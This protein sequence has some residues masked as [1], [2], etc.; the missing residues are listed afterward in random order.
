[1]T[2]PSTFPGVRPGWRPTVRLPTTETANQ[3]VQSVDLLRGLV[4]VI[5]AIDHVRDYFTQSR[6][7]PTDLTQTTVPLFATRWITHYCAPI[8]IFLAGVSAWMA[9]RRR[10]PAELS[11]LLLTRGLWLIMLEVT[12]VNFAW[13]FNL[14]FPGGIGLQVIWAIG[15]SMVAMAG[16][17]RLSRGTIGL[18]AFGFMAGHN[19][20]DPLDASLGGNFFWAVLHAP[21]AFPELNLVVR[22]PVL[23]WIGVM[24][25]GYVLGPLLERPAAA[26]NRALLQLGFAALAAFVLLRTLGIYG[27][28]SPWVK[29]ENPVTTALSFFNVT[30]YPPS[31]EYILMTLGPALIGLVLLER[32]RGPLGVWLAAFGRAPFFYYIAH[33]Y[34]IHSLALLAGVATGFGLS[35]MATSYRFMPQGYGFSLPVVYLVWLVVL[36][37]LYRPTKWF[38]DMK[39]KRKEWWWAYL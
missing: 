17:V 26:R 34:L 8:F 35:Q 23:P 21:N 11:H 1:M 13:Y 3:R 29:S 2:A 5:M 7:D 38:G 6:F 32:I 14:S 18:I 37:L 22:Y 24:A 33:L 10:T 16:L 31:L 9:G 27:D 15:L 39:A 12:V 25:A 36:V 30:K 28:P 19:L 4:M 20:L